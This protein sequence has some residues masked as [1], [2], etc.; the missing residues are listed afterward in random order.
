VIQFTDPYTGQTYVGVDYKDDRGIAEKMVKHA[1]KMK[2]RTSY[3]TKKT[4]PP[5]NPAPLDLCVDGISENDKKLSE[6]ELYNYTQLMDIMIQVTAIYDNG[7]QNWSD[8]YQ[9]P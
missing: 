6:S 3:C 1:N 5:Q 9:N 2:A 7:Y 8:D 4:T